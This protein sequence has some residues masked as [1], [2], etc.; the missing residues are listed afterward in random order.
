MPFLRA[1]RGRASCRWS[2]ARARACG[3]WPRARDPDQDTRAVIQQIV[4]L[5]GLSGDFV[6]AGQQLW[7]PRG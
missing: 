7:V 2:S 1:R 3:R 5:N 6:S 4:D